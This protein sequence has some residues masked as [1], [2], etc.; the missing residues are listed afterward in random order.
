MKRRATWNVLAILLCLMTLIPLANGYA[1]EITMKEQPLLHYIAEPRIGDVHPFYDAASGTWYMYYLEQDM[2]KLSFVLNTRLACST[3]LI[4]WTP[5]TLGY[6]GRVPATYYVI[7]VIAKDDHYLS[8]YGRLNDFWAI[9]SKDLVNWKHCGPE[10]SIVV[11]ETVFPSKA[12]DA[13]VF[14]DDDAQVYRCIATAYKSNEI[15]DWG[16]GEGIDCM[17]G[18]A[19]TSDDTPTTW[20]KMDTILRR[21]DGM[22]GEPECSQV[23]KIGNRWYIFASMG[24]RHPNH[25]GRLT[26]LIGDEG[27][28][29]IEQDWSIKE[30]HYLT[31]EDLCAAQIAFRDDTYYLWG[32]IIE[33][34]NAGIWGGHLNFPLEV[35][36]GEDGILYSRLA[37]EVAN[38][39]RGEALGSAQADALGEGERLDV[40]GKAQRYDA[41][42]TVTLAQDTVFSF[43]AGNAVVR[44]DAQA[45]QFAIMEN[46]T[47]PHVSY[48]LPKGY[49]TGENTLRIIAEGDMLEVFLNDEWSLSA[50]LSGTVD[51]YLVSAVCEKGEAANISLDL[52][53]LKTPAELPE[54]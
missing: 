21:F 34:W 5:V 4:H 20:G 42:L 33:N 50:R 7:D 2:S 49:L 6:D 44:L 25:V 32:W 17:W 45:G 53:A 41:D 9:Q 8:W 3:D 29:F 18:L 19:S 31:S 47:V 38:V 52:Y 46:A 22:K 30:E 37:D 35:Y 23:I 54:G 43:Q 48:A 10:Y 36:P 15:E 26:Y 11:D 13:F 12:R 40:L 14:F 1:E 16:I 39:I 24:R 28:P 27:V 51:T